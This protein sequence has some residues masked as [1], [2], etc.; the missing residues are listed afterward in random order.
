[1]AGIDVPIEAGIMPVINKRQVLKM[2]S[3]CGVKVPKKFQNILDKYE[4]NPIAMRDAGIAYAV[5][6]IVDLVTH[7]VDGVHLYTMNNPYIARNIYKA[8]HSLFESTQKGN[9][10]GSSASA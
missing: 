6:Q 5:D 9:P 1:M 2:A 7:G 4:D 3:L 8:T 10:G